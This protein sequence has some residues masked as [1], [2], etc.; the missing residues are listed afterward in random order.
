MVSKPCRDYLTTP[1]AH[2][3]CI[4]ELDEEH[5]IPSSAECEAL[6]EV[7]YSS[8]KQKC[9]PLWTAFILKTG[10]FLVLPITPHKDP[11]PCAGLEPDLSFRRR[12]V[13]LYV[14][15]DIVLDVMHW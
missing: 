12:L 5:V 3:D 14:T 13:L 10:Y 9:S 11:I 15:L 1:Y 2:S 4:S 8:P 6:F 7:F